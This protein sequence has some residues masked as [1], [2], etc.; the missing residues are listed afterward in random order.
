MRLVLIL[1]F[2]IP[3]INCDVISMTVLISKFI[4]RICAFLLLGA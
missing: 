1:V 4:A 2:K 3:K